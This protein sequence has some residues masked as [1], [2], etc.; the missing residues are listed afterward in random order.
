[1]TT[2][3]ELQKKVVKALETGQDPAP[4]LKELADLRAAIAMEAEKAELQKIADERQA[5]RDKAEVVK[6]KIQK[7]GEAI[8][9]FLKARDTVTT[10]LAPIVERAKE[11]PK[12]QSE[13]YAEYH[14]PGILVWTAKL[15]EGY[16]PKDLSVPMLEGKDG[17]MDCHDRAAQAVWYISAGLGLLQSLKREDRPFP[18]RPASEFEAIEPET[19]SCIVCS[20]PEVEAINNLL[21]Q[22]K[23]LRDIEAGFDISRSSLSRH[24]NNCLNLGAIKV[25]KVEK[26]T[27]TISANQTF[28]RG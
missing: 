26:E 16:L 15:P 14:D 9:I 8:D 2:I 3:T 4:I 18:E 11:L 28:F 1:M 10:E 27:P 24:K 7:Q 25:V 17:I 5:L 23:P 12:L 13:C 19:G 22:G 6:G 21:R 20:H